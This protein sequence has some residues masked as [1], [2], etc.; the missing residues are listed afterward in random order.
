MAE[1]PF[2]FYECKSCGEIR[3]YAH[4]PDDEWIQCACGQ[5]LASP[6]DWE[7]PETQEGVPAGA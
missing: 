7:P 3:D 5:F 1:C 6:V 2:S 4:V